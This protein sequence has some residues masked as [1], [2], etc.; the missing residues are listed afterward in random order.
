MI[1]ID[2]EDPKAVAEAQLTLVTNAVEAAGKVQPPI[3]SM[4][5]LR[6]QARRDKLEK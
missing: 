3:D 5:V 2:A 6:Q 4:E 1:E